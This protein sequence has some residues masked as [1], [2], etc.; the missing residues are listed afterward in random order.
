ME[1]GAFYLP[2]R[3]VSGGIERAVVDMFVSPFFDLLK[4]E[5]GCL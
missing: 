3:G 5:G 4:R 2:V 1:R